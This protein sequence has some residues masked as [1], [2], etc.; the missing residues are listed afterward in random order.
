MLAVKSISYA[1]PEA[2][3]SDSVRISFADFS[4]ACA[5]VS[6]KTSSSGRMILRSRLDRSCGFITEK[7][8]LNSLRKQR[9]RSVP[10]LFCKNAFLRLKIIERLENM[11][12]RQNVL[13]QYFARFAAFGFADDA[14]HFELIHQSAG[15]VVSD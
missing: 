1:L 3:L 14:G 13:D 10:L 8:G 4:S 2:I 9:N 15:A 6:V 5:V 12:Q 11:F 7:S